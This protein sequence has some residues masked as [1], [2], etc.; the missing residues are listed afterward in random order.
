[1]QEMIDRKLWV[2]PTGDEDTEIGREYNR[3][4]NSEWKRKERDRRT[5][6]EFMAWYCPSGQN[7]ARDGGKMQ[8]LG[9]TITQL[10]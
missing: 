1:M 4:M 8:V 3:Q 6:L 2:E 5:G 7:H 9:A 10:L